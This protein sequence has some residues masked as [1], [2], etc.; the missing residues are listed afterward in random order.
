MESESRS[1]A[2]IAQEEVRPFTFAEISLHRGFAFRLGQV[3][4]YG[5]AGMQFLGALP[6][7]DGLGK[8]SRIVIGQAKY[9]QG[10]GGLRR[11]L[12]GVLGLGHG[13]TGIARRR[14][15]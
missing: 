5:F 13:L 7:F 1:V 15:A 9:L 6:G 2:F 12:Y 3:S 8:P 14:A 10:F 4:G 11:L